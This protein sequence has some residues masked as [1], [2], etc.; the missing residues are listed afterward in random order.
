MALGPSSLWM[1]RSSIALNPYRPLVDNRI[2]YLQCAWQ[3]AKSFF[4]ILGKKDFYATGAAYS[5]L[6]RINN[7]IIPMVLLYY[8][9]IISPPT[10]QPHGI[11]VTITLV[12]ASRRKA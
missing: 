9:E 1:A 5:M 2:I 11:F 12:F 10:C 8:L 4:L 7:N 6:I 3:F